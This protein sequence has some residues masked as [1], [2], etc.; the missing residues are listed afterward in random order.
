M[1]V[2]RSPQEFIEAA[3]EAKHPGF[4][5]DQLPDPMVEAVEFCTRH[6]DDFVATSRSET[7]RA[8]MNEAQNLAKQEMELKAG[9]SDRRRNILSKKPCC[10]LRPSCVEPDLQT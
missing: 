3:L 10:S 8:M 2:H 9:M 7:L 4:L 1:G 6:S 5:S